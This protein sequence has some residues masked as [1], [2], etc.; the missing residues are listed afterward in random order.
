MADHVWDFAVLVLAYLVGAVPFSNLVAHRYAGLDLRHAGT[1]TTTPANLHRTAGLR[2]A[3]LAGVLEV[4]KGMVGP[5]LI[6]PDRPLL[7]A[8]A[9]GLAVTGHNWSPLLRGRGGRGISTA[10]G[11]L[12]VVAWPGA[13]FMF[14]C[15]VM[16]ILTRRVLVFMRAAAFALLPLLGL[17][18]GRRGLLLGAILVGPIGFKTTHEIFRRRLLDPLVR[19]GAKRSG[20][21]TDIVIRGCGRDAPP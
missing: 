15:L 3:V 12:L 13:V 10:T 4:A 9:G 1:G 17:I 21:G 8:V 19:R 11:A 18:D 2:P 20:D 5:A 14:G 16:G 7:A 6:G